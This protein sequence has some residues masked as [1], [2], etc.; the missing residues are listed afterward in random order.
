VLEREFEVAGLL[1]LDHEGNSSFS[2]PEGEW[3][4]DVFVR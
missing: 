2:V 3:F 4:A 1:D